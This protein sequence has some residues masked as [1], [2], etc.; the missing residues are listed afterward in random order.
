MHHR[1]R[2]VGRIITSRKCPNFSWGG[3][4]GVSGNGAGG[5]RSAGGILG[6]VGEGSAVGVRTFVELIH[7]PQD[8]H[9]GIHDR[10]VG[11]G[12]ATLKV[13]EL[14][15]SIF[16]SRILLFGLDCEERSNLVNDEPLSFFDEVTFLRD[17][18][19]ES[20]GGAKFLVVG[21]F[22]EDGLDFAGET[23]GNFD[24]GDETINLHDTSSF[25]MCAF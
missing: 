21:H 14:V 8:T 11:F 5:A 7:A 23:L 3:E 1:L 10:A 6:T 16:G 20:V 24:I 22:F 15:D 19:L 12:N 17:G 9:V 2:W 25:L 18:S 4:E 13:E